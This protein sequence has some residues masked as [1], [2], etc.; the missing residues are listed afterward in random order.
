MSTLT[1]L[2]DRVVVLTGAGSGIGR[3][4][5]ELLLD[6]GARVVAG[7]FRPDTLSDA[8]ERWGEDRLVALGA[9]VRDPEASTQL[10]NAGVERFGRV[11]SV[12]ANAGIGFFGGVLDYSAEQVRQMVDTNYLGSVWLSRAAI[13]H[14]RERGGG[15]DIIIVASV[16]GLGIGGGNESVYAGSKAAQIQFAQSLQ[17]EIRSEDIRV[18]TIAPAA[19]N[20]G[21]AQAT[22][23]FGDKAPED[24]DFLQPA[25]I[26]Q[27]I[28]TALGQPRHM[29]TE[30]WTLW[31]MA[32]A[33]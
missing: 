33:G 28:V 4:T 32:E 9:D 7:D 18:T 14:Y 16:A 8:V 12:V 10:V 13:A 30:L 15:G 24:G 3:A 29:R 27:A 22:G 31:S 25:D 11:D 2:T 23:R 21:F 26:G 6:A 1:P 20:T 17:R 19:A 5:R